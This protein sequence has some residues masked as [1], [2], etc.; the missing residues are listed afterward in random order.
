M[1]AGGF[2]R[3]RTRLYMHLEPL[4][5]KDVMQGVYASLNKM[6]LRYMEQLEGVLVAYTRVRLLNSAGLIKDDSPLVHFYV[7]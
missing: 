7:R 4:W 5:M 3:V 1:D 6:L 2:R